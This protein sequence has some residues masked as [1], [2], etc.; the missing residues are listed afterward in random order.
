MPSPT[1]VPVVARAVGVQGLLGQASS[2]VL[3]RDGG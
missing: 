3:V 2:L 1:H